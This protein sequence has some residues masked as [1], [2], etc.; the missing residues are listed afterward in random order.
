[1]KCL[2]LIEPLWNID[3]PSNQHIGLEEEIKEEI[4]RLYG[5]HFIR[6]CRYPK[7][8]PNIVPVVKKNGKLRVCIDF[9]PLNKAM[10]KDDYPLPIADLLV[11]AAAHHK[12][13]SFM[14]TYVLARI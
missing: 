10:P 14:D 7:W 4:T 9:R 11:D 3:C 6:P 8:V 5:A 13:I 2:D 1:M 12:I